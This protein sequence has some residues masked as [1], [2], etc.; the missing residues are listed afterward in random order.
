MNPFNF[1][2][3]LWFQ[4]NLGPGS[5][6]CEGLSLIFELSKGASPFSSMGDTTIDPSKGRQ[7]VKQT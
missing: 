6:G 4:P 7:T 2:Q 5:L 3:R 1:E